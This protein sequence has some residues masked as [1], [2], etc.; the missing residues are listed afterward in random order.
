MSTMPSGINHK[1]P[2]VLP[3]KVQREG[4]F[5]YKDISTLSPPADPSKPASPPS[6]TIA[7]QKLA[8]NLYVLMNPALPPSRGK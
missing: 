8:E 3:T 1:G 4:P 6:M 7:P 2:L 5:A